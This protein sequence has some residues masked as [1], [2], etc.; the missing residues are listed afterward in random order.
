MH[1][2][3]GQKNATPITKQNGRHDRPPLRPL[4][5]FG[6]DQVRLEPEREEAEEDWD[7]ARQHHDEDLGP[8]DVHVLF[9]VDAPESKAQ[10]FLPRIMIGY[11][12]HSVRFSYFD[13]VKS[14]RPIRASNYKEK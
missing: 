14:V 10:Y 3:G 1:Q 13:Q 2:R 8:H 5:I 9:S 12:T 11:F 7:D 6:G 4:L